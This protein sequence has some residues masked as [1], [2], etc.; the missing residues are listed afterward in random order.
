[1]LKSFTMS[2]DLSRLLAPKSVAVIGGGFW[3][4]NVIEQLHKIGF[5]GEIWP[6][7]PSK[8]ELG[9]LPCIPS[10]RA[11]P[12]PPDACFIGVNRNATVDIARDLSAMGAGGAVCFASGFREASREDA[13]AAD[14]QAEL[15]KAAGAMPILGPNCYGYINALDQ[16]A[17]WPDQHGL[18]K[19]DKG[20][21]IITQS[22][23][24]AINFTMQQ[25]GLPIAY[26]I[27]AGNQAQTSLS[28]IAQH[29]LSDPRVTALGIHIEGFG[30]IPA[31]EAL[32]ASTD[33]PVIALKV[34]TSEQAQLATITHTAS[35]AGSSMGADALLSRLG[36]GKATDPENFFEALKIAHTFGALPNTSIT[37]MS[38]SGGEASLMADA[39]L[40]HGLSCPPLN[41]AQTL[42]LRDALGPLVALANPLDY[43]TY[44][45]GDA[46]K[47][48]DTFA[49]MADRHAAL[50]ILV[51]DLP[52]ADRCDPHAWDCAI[53][54][55]KSAQTTTKARF[56]VLT[57]LP[58]NLPE[59]LA[60]D[61]MTH[62]IVP[63]SGMSSGLAGVA[64]AAQC[65]PVALIVPTLQSSM[66]NAPQTVLEHDAKRLLKAVGL[67]IPGT[68]VMH[69]EDD[70]HT[71]CDTADKRYVLKSIGAAHK[72]ETGGVHLNQSAAALRQ[73]ARSM[74]FPLLVEEMIEGGIAEMLLA[75]TRDPA[76]GFVLTIG[77][78]G[79]MTELHN[80]T[81]HLMIPATDE[82]IDTALNALRIAPVLRGY[83]GKSGINR[84]AL[85]NTIHALQQFV[86][87]HA[88]QITE[89]EINPLIC[90]KDAVFVAD[91][92]L[93]MDL[94]P[95]ALI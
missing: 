73:T 82:E 1:M 66:P 85:I 81:A 86:T 40:N 95:E 26:M 68:R 60:F 15:I 31:F 6:V 51:V 69:S 4:E 54:A 39:A 91:A 87:Q 65:N 63:L 64:I 34:G 55:I 9:G 12:A 28:D 24:I 11:L 74:A 89:L 46:D 90:T 45:W 5:E 44:I 27:T 36:V 23:N 2:R 62:G 71:F 84:R 25:R 61:L 67:P 56:A 14:L 16:A 72:S 49:A 30:D 94:K 8:T 19:I 53:D 58:E 22:S 59:P 52:R 57:M 38:C 42:G 75:V 80:D 10:L 88:E 79:I 13:A 18:T 21:A 48:A 50:N 43:H 35:M 41:E 3:G 83:R 47:M 77:A 37:S 93:Q 76:H 29:V 32:I 7:H 78:G 20:V 17:L 70:L 33:K 92:L